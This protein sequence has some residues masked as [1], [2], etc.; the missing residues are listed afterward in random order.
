MDRARKLS[1]ETL[2]D[3]KKQIAIIK[4]FIKKQ[5][6]NL[7]KKPQKRKNYSYAGR[8]LSMA[9]S[10]AKKDLRFYEKAIENHHL[11]IQGIQPQYPESYVAFRRRVLTLINNG[12]PVQSI[13]S[14]I[15]V[16]DTVIDRVI[17][18]HKPTKGVITNAEEYNRT[19]S[20]Y[21]CSA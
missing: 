20:Q 4:D 9:L 2:N 12:T 21:R 6:P 15:N 5:E 7:L 19:L 10:E 3:Y 14:Q 11:S 1:Q 17:N 8:Y 18:H 16:S 13:A